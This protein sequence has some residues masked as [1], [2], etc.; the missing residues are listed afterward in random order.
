MGLKPSTA[1]HSLNVTWA[2]LPLGLGV[3]ADT[4]VMM[5]A[6]TRIV[7]KFLWRTLKVH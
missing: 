1:P 5:Q 3:V 2:F 7:F 6:Q 4:Y